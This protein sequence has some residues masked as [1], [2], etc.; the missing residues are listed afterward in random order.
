[1]EEE[2]KQVTKRWAYLY[3]APTAFI[4]GWW[5]HDLQFHWRELADYQYGWIVA[6]LAVYLVW[7]RWPTMPA[8]DVPAQFWVCALLA[9]IGTPFVLVAEL[10]KQAIA[11]T[12]AAS[13][14]LSIGCLLFLT[15]NLLYLRGWRTLR[16]FGFP[17][18][19]FWLAVPLPG[20]LWSPVV[21]RLQRAVTTID[22]ALLNLLGIPAVQQ[23]NV[24]Q[25][26]DCLVGIDEAC[27]GIR[28]L[29]SSAMAALFV[30][31]MIFKSASSQACFLA[32][33][34]ALALAANCLRSLLL[35]WTAHRFGTAALHQ[36]HDAAGWSVFAFTAAGLV[37][38]GWLIIRLERVARG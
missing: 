32:F 27:S 8:K 37:C 31:N 22:V 1:M 2:R 28:S 21:L 25:L 14:S 3:Y 30:G 35:S 11:Q 26:P 15:A 34:L 16:H 5:I 19:F 6:M 10:Y 23:A 13:F 9:L 20:L 33:G 18:L 24:I 38:A 29:Q 17:L 4:L 7:Q 36:W 12:P